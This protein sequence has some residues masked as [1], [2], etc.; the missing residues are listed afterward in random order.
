MLSIE[1]VRHTGVGGDHG[2]ILVTELHIHEANQ[3]AV[4]WLSLPSLLH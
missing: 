3:V 4:A 2:L 1:D